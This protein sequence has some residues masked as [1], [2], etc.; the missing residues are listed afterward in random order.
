LTEGKGNKRIDSQQVR[1]GQ[2]RKG[3]RR[4]RADNSESKGRLK[5][6]KDMRKTE[7]RRKRRQ[8]K[9]IYI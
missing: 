1:S 7:H 6:N 5:V 4:G 8:R 3:V 2:P 9:Y